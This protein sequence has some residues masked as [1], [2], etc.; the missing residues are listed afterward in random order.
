MWELTKSFYFEA[1]HA[2]PGTTLGEASQEIHGHSFRAEVAIRGTPDPATGIWYRTA[3][4]ATR[5]PVLMGGAAVV[6]FVLLALPLR[7]AQFGLPDDR[8]LPTSSSSHAAQQAPELALDG[9]R[10]PPGRHSFPCAR[11]TSSTSS[12]SCE[13]AGTKPPA[14][15]RSCDGRRVGGRRLGLPGQSQCAHAMAPSAA[16]PC[17]TACSG[18]FAARPNRL[19]RRGPRQPASLTCSTRAGD[20]IL[21]HV[22]HC[23]GQAACRC[24]QSAASPAKA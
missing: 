10:Q 19:L 16:A 21:A 8:V 2:L 20:R 9:V 4:A 1:A 5:Q 18:F 15:I 24:R 7:H 6:I 12:K 22:A 13:K 14:P 17:R 3:R 23:A 11:S